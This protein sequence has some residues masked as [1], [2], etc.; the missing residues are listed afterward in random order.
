MSDFMFLKRKFE[1][2]HIQEDEA[3]KPLKKVA[4]EEAFTILGK[5]I[6]TLRLVAPLKPIC[7][8]LALIEGTSRMHKD[9]LEIYIPR[10]LPI[11]RADDE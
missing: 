2:L 4:V 11:A 7:K 5:Q 8:P 9:L 3:P 6:N 1:A 10:P